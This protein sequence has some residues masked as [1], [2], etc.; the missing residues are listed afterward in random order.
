MT[1]RW[2]LSRTV[3]QAKDLCKHVEKLLNAQRDLLSPQAIEAIETAVQQGR[4]AIKDGADDA[5]LK[6]QMEAL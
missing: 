6:K 4:Q 1:L 2:F 5:A 3:R